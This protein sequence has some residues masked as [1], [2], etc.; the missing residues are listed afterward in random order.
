MPEP[1]AGAGVDGDEALREQVVAR[2]VPAVVV[3][4]R[5]R[6]RQVDDAQ[7][8][9]AGGVGPHVGVA[10]VLPRRAVVDGVGP[11][12]LHPELV[13]AGDGVKRPHVL[14]GPHVVAADV[15]ARRLLVGGALGGGDVLDERADDDDVVD[16]DGGRVP[17]EVGEGA[18]QPLAQVDLAGLAEPGVALAGAGVE[19]HELR[20]QGRDHAA[21]LAVG[22]PG[23][24]PRLPH[25]HAVAG[26]GVPDDLAGGRLEGRDGAQP[27][28]E[29]QQ[30]ARHQGGRLRGDGAAGGLAVP[31]GVGN[32]RLPPCDLEAGHG[33][34][35]DLVEGQVLGAGLVRRVGRPLDRLT[36]GGERRRGQGHRSRQDRRRDLHATIRP[37]RHCCPPGI[38]ASLPH[39]PAPAARGGS[40]RVAPR[41]EGADSS[42]SSSAGWRAPAGGERRA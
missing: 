34:G 39:L 30:A 7:L 18:Q 29:V 6:Q 2:P 13:L 24:A 28:A 21:L 14:A 36:G 15:A 3:V 32:H 27:G 20:A 35:V 16:D 8:L 23:D 25:P 19:R 31:D 41:P 33:L 22:P 17:V 11:P 1:L 4:G 9:V 40:A 38:G 26:A 12:R 5:G 42:P 10:A 37:L